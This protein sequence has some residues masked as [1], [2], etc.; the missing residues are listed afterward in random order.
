[1]VQIL[2]LVLFVVWGFLLVGGVRLIQHKRYWLG[3]ALIVETILAIAAQAALSLIP[4]GIGEPLIRISRREFNIIAVV[5]AIIL[6]V[7]LFFVLRK[8]ATASRSPLTSSSK[9]SLLTL[10]AFPLVAGISLYSLIFFGTPERERERDPNKRVIVLPS[11]FVAEIYTDAKGVMDN[12]T[13]MTFAPDGKLFVAD[14]AGN[15]WLCEDANKDFKIDTINKFA[16]G[17]QLLVGLAWQGNELYVSSSGK[18]EALKDTNG[19]GKVDE[20]RTV[21]DNLPSMILMPHSNNSLTF[22][23][24][25]RIYFGVGS[26]VRSGREPT[27][28]GGS[29]LSVSTDGGDVKV[30]ARGFGN[31]F[32][33]AFNKTGQMFGGDN[34]S[35]GRDGESAPDE[36][37]HI[38]QGG[39]YGA[40]E[41][42]PLGLMGNAPLVEFPTHATPTGLTF[43]NGKTYPTEYHDTAF[44]SLWNRG[45]ID[46]IVINEKG[47]GKYSAQRRAFASGF[48]YPIDAIVGPDD[49]L[50]IADFGTSAIYRIVY[51]GKN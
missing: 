10:F 19:D 23:P 37:N 12:P 48:L 9:F 8:R 32:D 34:A 46:Q 1:M 45:E 25:G 33:V 20:R 36:F 38:S 43:Y 39:E 2:S 18:I 31:V 6:A 30:F 35:N 16:E 3:G 24:D 14:I 44:I 50:Y 17:F 47:D 13:V 51:V 27:A 40:N 22:G 7:L 42:D 15:L 11:G 5:A 26:T 41:Q 49:N 21:A 4:V 29:V 28:L